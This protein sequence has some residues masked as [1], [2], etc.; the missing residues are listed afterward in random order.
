M[1]IE[2]IYYS[3]TGHSQKIAKAIGASIGVEPK[4]IKNN[5]VLEEVDL[6]FVV[7]GIYSSRTS[8]ELQ[9]F[10]INNPGTK[11]KNAV[12]ITSCMSKVMGQNEIRAVMKLNGINVEQEEFICQGSFLFFGKGHPNDEDIE[13]AVAFANRM[14]LK[15]H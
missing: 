12:L 13:K 5:P 3:K 7:G 11:I 8:P 4:N 10:M 1:N 2:I 9:S 15:Y 6:L 14:V